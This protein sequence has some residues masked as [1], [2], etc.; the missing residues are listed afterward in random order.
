MQE[1]SPQ[2]FDW[3]PTECADERYP[4]QLLSGELHCS[5]GELVPVPTAKIINNGWGEIGSRR[6]VGDPLKPVPQHLE[7]AW[8]SYTEDQFFAGTLELPQAELTQ[9]F[10]DGFHEPLTHELVTWSKIVVGMGLGGH[11]SVWLAGSG[12]VR[13][14]ASAKLEPAEIDWAE[15][16]DNPEISRSQFVRST[17]AARLSRAELKALAEH[18]PPV[19][20]WPRYS[21]PCRWRIHVDGIQVP[22]YMFLRSFNGDRRFYDF[23]KPPLDEMDRVPKRMEITWLARSGRKLLTKI[24]FDEA[25]VFGAFDKAGAAALDTSTTTLRIEFGTRARVSMVVESQ[26]TRIPLTRSSVEVLSLSD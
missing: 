3:L 26:G 2:S 5:D 11:T 15:V 1:S 12:L 17:L 22:L 14:V 20:T 10:T 9:L 8:F 25:E 6:L 24:G 4:M 18:G 7:A 23:A 19:S 21:S 16:L 13:E